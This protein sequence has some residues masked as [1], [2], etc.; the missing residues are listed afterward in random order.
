M[1]KPTMK[2]LVT[3]STA[4]VCYADVKTNK[5]HIDERITLYEYTRNES[6]FKTKLKKTLGN[7]DIKI[8]SVKEHSTYR[9]MYEIN[10]E[11]FVQNGRRC[12]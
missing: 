7:S 6:D 9:R 3:F 2:K 4:T 1:Y 11:D 10:V 12:C 5:I 8:L